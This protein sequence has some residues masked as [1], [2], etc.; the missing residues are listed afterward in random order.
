MASDL[1]LH[2]FLITLLGI[3]SL[4]WVKH[5][6][7]LYTRYVIDQTKLLYKGSAAL[8]FPTFTLYCSIT[9]YY[10]DHTT[11]CLSKYMCNQFKEASYIHLGRDIAFPTILH[12]RPVTTKSRTKWSL[13]FSLRK[14]A[15]SNI[16]KTLQPK[17]RKIFR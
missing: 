10:Y 11:Y 15:Y 4:Q 1:G 7:N 17:K 3:S 2:C 13:F 14:R 5:F 6:R 8:F 9:L 16:L 12:V